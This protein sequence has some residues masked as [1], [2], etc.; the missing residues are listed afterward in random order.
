M[1]PVPCV[2]AAAIARVHVV[3]NLLM[4]VGQR[5]PFAAKR[6]LAGSHSLA[7]LAD[8]SLFGSAGQS[9]LLWRY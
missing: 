2:V 1:W 9:P 7:V 3:I 4:G 5:L 6:A 8:S